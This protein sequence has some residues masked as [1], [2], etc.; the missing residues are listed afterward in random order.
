[1]LNLALKLILLKCGEHFFPL[2]AAYSYT[3]YPS[4]QILGT[5]YITGSITSYLASY[6][7]LYD[8]SIT[9]HDLQLILPLQIITS[10][11]SQ[12]LGTYLCMRFNPKLTASLGSG[13]VVLAV[14]GASYCKSYWS[15]LCVYGLLYGIGVGIAVFC[16]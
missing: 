4:S 12:Y 13:C 10:T 14:F 6:L 1:M 5:I 15:I 3:W 9:L 2:R 7:R 8:S 11:F 16:I